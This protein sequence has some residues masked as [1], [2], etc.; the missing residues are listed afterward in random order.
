[1]EGRVGQL[2]VT[3]DDITA[4]VKGKIDA[5]GG[6]GEAFGWSLTEKGFYIDDSTNPNAENY[7]LKVDSTGLAIHGRG[8]FSGSIAIG[9]TGGSPNF[10]VDEDGNVTLRGSITWK[11]DQSPV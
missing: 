4:T 10:E 8:T 1:M 11:A 7:V 2:E 3:A 5:E 6:D 9:G